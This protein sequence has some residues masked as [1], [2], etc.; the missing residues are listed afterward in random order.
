MTDQAQHLHTALRPVTLGALRAL[1]RLVASGLQ[2]SRRPVPRLILD[3]PEVRA[4]V[5]DAVEWDRVARTT[6]EALG[7]DTAVFVGEAAIAPSLGAAAP[8][9]RDGLRSWSPAGS[10]LDAFV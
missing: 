4:Y 9:W 7:A 10:V 6:M 2:L 3:E 1:E 8:E 5:D